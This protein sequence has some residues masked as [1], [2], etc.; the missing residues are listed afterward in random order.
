MYSLSNANDPLSGWGW[1]WE[2][3]SKPFQLGFLFLTKHTP[4]AYYCL[5]LDPQVFLSLTL[6]ILSPIPAGG[7]ASIWVSK[8]LLAHWNPVHLLSCF[9]CLFSFYI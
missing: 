8:L 2:L 9:A 3:V 4:F 1:L 5:F 7:R 6:P